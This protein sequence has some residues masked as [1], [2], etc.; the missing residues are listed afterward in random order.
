M[1]LIKEG[2]SLD[3]FDQN[4]TVELG[5]YTYKKNVYHSETVTDK[6]GHK[7]IYC[8]DNSGSLKLLVARTVDEKP[9]RFMRH[10]HCKVYYLQ[11]KSVAV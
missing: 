7:S 8:Y 4:Q 9:K 1:I 6:K 5:T 3:N 10:F 11:C 2:A